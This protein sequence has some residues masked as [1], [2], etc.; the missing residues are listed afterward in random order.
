MS[1]FNT[2]IQEDLR[3]VELLSRETDGRVKLVSTTGNP[4]RELIIELAYPTAG[5][6]SFPNSIQHSTIVKIELLSRY[7]F[8]APS[9]KITTPIYHP[10]VF[11]SGQICLGTKWLP[12]QNLDLL[13]R[14]IIKIITFDE[15]I[16]NESSPANGAALRWYR[17]AVVQYPNS[18]PTTKLSQ[19]QQ[20]KKTISWSNVE[21]S[22]VVNCSNCKTSLRLPRGKQGNVNCPSCKQGFY[23]ET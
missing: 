2:R 14:R 1:A 23:I 16:L 6:T 5:S 4:V 9:A 19:Q 22:V 11:S 10:N 12:T 21:T 13:I 3:K 18:F 15:S 17:T 7:P 8:Q 20:P